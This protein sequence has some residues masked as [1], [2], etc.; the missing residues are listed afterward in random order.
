MLQNIEDKVGRV[1]PVQVVIP[2][3]QLKEPQPS[4][5]PTPQIPES[6]LGKLVEMVAQGKAG[7]A[8]AFADEFN[9]MSK[10]IPEQ[11]RVTLPENVMQFDTQG[12]SGGE[13]NQPFGNPN[14]Q[15]YGYDKNGNPNINRGVDLS[16]SAL[17]PQAAPQ[18]GNWVVIDAYTG[19]GFNTGWGK[20]V[21]L[22]NQDTGETIRRSHLNDVLV[23]P[24]EVVTGKVIG[25][26]GRTGRT[27]GYHQ[28]V[29]YT[30]SAGQLAD[31]TKSPYYNEQPMP[32]QEVVQ[33]KSGNKNFGKFIEREAK[34]TGLP[35]K[36]LDAQIQ[37][38]SSG[39][40]NAVSSAGAVGVSQ[41]IPST[42][43]AYGLRV[44]NTV[45]ER[46]DPEKS[47]IAQANYMADL[48]KQYGSIERALS[49][50]NSGKPD[51]YL[52]PNFARGETYNYVRKI[53]NL[54]K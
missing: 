2:S 3:L 26:T 5:I 23:K 54:M 38:E 6:S 50:Y 53:M 43:R 19:N 18:K 14:A 30:N 37:A 20:S 9:N 13:I 24:G 8:M 27:T 1:E 45:D 7:E 15:L 33:E 51:A 47:I 39:N 46:L 40:P 48:L 4:D 36:L 10:Q 25:T 12:T 28:D 49:A 16:A 35:I 11:F 34:R 21:V 41:F 22:K 32:R 42:A 44:D 29:E 52:N 31:F 17:Q